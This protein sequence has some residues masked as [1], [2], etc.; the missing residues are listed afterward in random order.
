MSA[1]ILRGSDKL[2]QMANQIAAFFASQPGDQAV[3]GVHDHLVA[4][5][6]PRMR[7]EIVEHLNKGGEGLAP[8]SRQAVERL[9]GNT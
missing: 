1:T 2:V 4:F 3:A 5:W 7:R 6:T 8:L 9:R